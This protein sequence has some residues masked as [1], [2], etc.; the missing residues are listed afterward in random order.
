MNDAF[1]YD[2]PTYAD[3]IPEPLRQKLLQ[4]SDPV[5]GIP[6]LRI[7]SGLRQEFPRLETT[8]A[9]RFVCA[10]YEAC[11][12][13]LATILSQRLR[14]RQFI[15]SKTLSYGALNC[16]KHYLADDYLTVLGCRD[17]AKR[18]VVGPLGEADPALVPVNQQPR[19]VD[20]PD[21]LRGEHVTLFGPPDSKKMCI[22]AMNALH[23]IP[24]DEP[25]LITELVTAG[26]QVPRWGAD[27]E[28]SQTPLIRNILRASDNLK[29]CFE[30][31]IAFDETESGKSYRL[32]KTQ[33][34]LPIKRI[35]GL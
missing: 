20:V 7:S 10:L 6:G 18:V 30:Q 29:D 34:A 11:K 17:D 31:T 32:N 3:Y 12:S 28:D 5:G 19:T 35:A 8:T 13:P 14:D 2:V 16:D 9:L 25:A 1:S 33:L 4:E 24:P 15:D 21:F 27:N 22:N 26:G 23:R